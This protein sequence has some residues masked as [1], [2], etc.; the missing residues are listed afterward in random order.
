M[1]LQRIK[2]LYSKMIKN[3]L[4]SRLI[5]LK[6]LRDRWKHEVIANAPSVFYGFTAFNALRVGN[7][8][9]DPIPLC[10]SRFWEIS[11]LNWIF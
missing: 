9:I 10:C 5:T 7:T 3:A 4:D 8:V 6:I 11:A 2:N 1:T